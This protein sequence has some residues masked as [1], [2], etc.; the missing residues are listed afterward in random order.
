MES[1]TGYDISA[2]A[3]QHADELLLEQRDQAYADQLR[4]VVDARGLAWVLHEL[5]TWER[6][7]QVRRLESV[8]DAQRELLDTV[9]A[10]LVET[11]TQ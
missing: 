7:A 6:Q 10:R 1:E 4:E 9:K 11:G 2:D 5:A 8:Q 3:E